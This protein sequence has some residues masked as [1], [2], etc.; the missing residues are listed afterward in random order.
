MGG[1]VANIARLAKNA[2]VLDG[3]SRGL[4]EE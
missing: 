4:T 1:S 2:T 3:L